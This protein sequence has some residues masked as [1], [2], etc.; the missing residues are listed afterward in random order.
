MLLETARHFAAT[1]QTKSIEF[2]WPSRA[3]FSSV[4][5]IEERGLKKHSRGITAVRPSGMHRAELSWRASSIEVRRI[6]L[7]VPT[8]TATS[9]PVHR[10]CMDLQPLQLG[11]LNDEELPRMFPD[12]V[13]FAFPL[14]RRQSADYGHNPMRIIES[15]LHG[16]SL[17]RC[18][19]HRDELTAALRSAENISC[20]STDSSSKSSNLRSRGKSAEGCRF[21]TLRRIL[22]LPEGVEGGTTIPT[23]STYVGLAIC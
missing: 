1:G 11:S 16:I 19:L 21:K 17:L 10:A 15:V 5:S 14:F 3:N 20:T 2:N 22:V 23:I 6:L 18:R 12:D 7:F 8:S 9:R 13:L 4:R